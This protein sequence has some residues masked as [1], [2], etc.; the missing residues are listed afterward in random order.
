MIT[1]RARND[2]EEKKEAGVARHTSI[3]SWLSIALA[4]GVEGSGS[5]SG[6]GDVGCIPLKALP[7]LV[8]PV[9]CVRFLRL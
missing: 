9:P 7:S 5:L 2:R 3:L 6:T 1:G 8:S 4:D